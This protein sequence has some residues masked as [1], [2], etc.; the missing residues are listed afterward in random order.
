MLIGLHP[1]F[2]FPIMIMR[3]L[4]Y[5]SDFANKPNLTL[6]KNTFRCQKD[7]YLRYKIKKIINDS[8]N[9]IILLNTFETETRLV[10]NHDF[11]QN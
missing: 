8:R 4:R 10:Y 5:L 6:L 7:V 11:L 3:I 1:D 2:W 9:K